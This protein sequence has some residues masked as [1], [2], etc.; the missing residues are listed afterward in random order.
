MKKNLL[1]SLFLIILG[2]KM[3]AQY[4]TNAPLTTYLQ[5]EK[6]GRVDPDT[7]QPIY[8]LSQISKAAEKYFSTVDINKKG[9]GYKP[10]KRWENHWKYF[11][12]KEGYILSAETLYQAYKDKVT[13]PNALNTTA[14]WSNIGPVNA[15]LL[16]YTPGT[17]RINQMAV[18]PINDQ[19]WYAGAPSG[20]LWKSFD[21]GQSWDPIFDE[22]PQIG[23]S[24]IAID[25]NDPD[26]IYIATG[27][28]DA[29]DSYSIGV[30]KSEDGGSTWQETDLNAARMGTANA[31]NEIVI[32]PND[33]SIIFVAGTN[34]FYKSTD[35]GLTFNR[36]P[37]EGRTVK[38][39]TDFKLKPDNPDIIYA[40]TND[41]FYRSTDGGDSFVVSTSTVIPDDFGRAV[42]GVSPADPYAVY[43]L[44]ADT[45]Q[46]N[47]VFEGLYRSN[48]DGVTFTKTAQSADILESSQAW[49]DLAIAVDPLDVNT[50]YIGCLNIWKSTDGGN[51]FN[52]INQWYV[53]DEAFSHADIHTLKFFNNILYAGTDGGLYTSVDGGMTFT[54]HSNSGLMTSQF[55]RMDMANDDASKIVGGTQDNAGF[56]FNNNQWNTWTGGDGMDYEIDPINSNISYGFTQFGST[57]WITTQNGLNLGYAEAPEQGNWITPLTINANGEVF[58][59]YQAVYKLNNS[60]WTKLSDN[61]TG[62]NIDDLEASPNNPNLMYAAENDRLFISE[63]GGEDFRGISQ[64]PD[65]ITDM[66][67]N[68]NDN[69]IIYVTTRND[70]IKVTV[71][72]SGNAEKTFITGDLPENQAYLSIIHQ[73]KDLKN[74]LFVGTSLGV[75]RTDDDL[76]SDGIWEDFSNNLPNTEVTDLDISIKDAII[77]ASTY[78]RGIFTSPINV[79]VADYDVS[80]LALRPETNRLSSAGFS[81]QIDIQNSGLNTI[82]EVTINYSINGE[83]QESISYEVSIPAEGEIT[84]DL[85]AIDESLTGQITLSVSITTPEDAWTDNNT[86]EKSLLINSNGNVGT[87]YDGET[88][89]TELL[90]Y[91]DTFTTSVWELGTPAG[92]LLNETAS[93]DKA[94]ATNLDGDHPNMTRGYLLSPYYNLSEAYSPKLTFSMAFNLETNWD[95][96][97]VQYTTDQGENWRVL[98]TINSGPNWYNSDR[99]EQTAGNDCYNC[100]GAQWTGTQAAFNSGELSF[101]PTIMTEYSYDFEANK[102]IDGIDL[103][104]ES[105]IA[106]RIVF[107]SDQAV[108]EEGVVID[109]FVI[110]F[111]ENDDDDD[112]GILDMDDNCPLTPNADQSDLDGDGV[113]DVRDICPDTP[114]GEEVDENGCSLSQKDFELTITVEGEG[115][116]SEE[117]ISTP[118]IYKGTSQVKL[119]AVPTEGWEFIEWSGD[120]VGTENPFTI[121]IDGT[122]SVTAIFAKKDSDGDG[123]PDL[124]DNC[125]ATPS[126]EVVDENGCSLSQIDFELIVTIEGEGTVSKEL[127]YEPSIYKGTS[128]VKLTAVPTEGWEFIEWSGDLVGTDNPFTIEI[129]GDKSVTAIFTKKDTDGDG[130]PD[131]EDNC[132]TTQNTDQSDLDGDGI[133][134]VCDTDLDNDGVLNEDDQCPDTASGEEVDENG[135]SLSQKDF[136]LTVTI[137]GEG[138][139]SEELISAPSIYKG[140]SQVKLTAV[141]TE[142]WEFIEWSGDLVSTENPFT[143]EID[144]A[145][146]I[147]AIFAKKDSDG[148]GVPDLDDN[149]PTTQNTDQSD[150][151]NDGIG[152][153]CD[154]DLDNDGVL[155]EIDQCPNTTPGATVNVN[156]CE[157][158][159]LPANAFTIQSTAITC[160]GNSDGSITV[161]LASGLPEGTYNAVLSE[162]GQQLAASTFTEGIVSFENL[163]GGNYQLCFTSGSLAGFERCAEVVIYEPEPLSVQS[164][165][166]AAGTEVA[167]ELT[168]GEVFEITLNGKKYV[169]SK[170]SINLPLDR[171]ENTVEVRG[172][173]DCQGIYTE[174]IVLSNK[175][176]IYPNPVVNGKVSVFL[177]DS[178][179]ESASAELYDFNGSKIYGKE[180]A[181]IDGVIELNVNGLRPGIYI[182]QIRTDEKMINHKLV[183]R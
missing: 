64:F 85:P 48:N 79:E 183:I 153:V 137:E 140:T 38:D 3:Q 127:I 59:G 158:V 36:S 31:L 181:A 107:E 56:I 88:T 29:L 94:W 18:D 141:P 81:P 33:N 167:L 23:V 142:G 155:N 14:D 179:I 68:S 160:S 129:D 154:T 115:T 169:T 9:S 86:I 80:L 63:D 43:L 52:R 89:E 12:D 139:V 173:Q 131:L 144:G 175:V 138:T 149:C 172:S 161:T 136:E 2:F 30:M 53:N 45:R 114:S 61:L 120:L 62:S 39:V 20:G 25:K 67:V 11:T 16:R 162:N 54:D 41:G 134:D 82:E 103:T 21:A 101:D 8:T 108:T 26:L 150:L 130:I 151:D 84:L 76:I 156:G 122:K 178:A 168:G 93:G 112:D 34:G 174:K 15:G 92:T 42:I 100:V 22:Y 117:L 60:G 126:G 70:V 119:T 40:V 78:G 128:Q 98:G 91:N 125:P 73:Q 143:I 110:S 75:Y 74:S 99:T 116:V 106:F 157:V 165:V 83:E 148:D 72:E 164:I 145:K 109:D 6:S 113:G 159:S 180:Q 66:S 58:S 132:P 146:S 69:R 111:E 71:P 1:L 28:D 24:G 50:V 96:V 87:L 124:D 118:S 10:F 32:H 57:L 51:I 95:L 13:Q 171:I 177:G 163:N 46:N 152:D 166:N 7:G 5:N 19:I 55:Y 102:S 90:T 37:F 65:A 133:G 170:S 35:S 27:D 44:Y 121:E 123:V 77:A 104:A 17:G 97:Y 147:T 4:K 49:F 135:C 47:Y 176:F 105:K 182:L